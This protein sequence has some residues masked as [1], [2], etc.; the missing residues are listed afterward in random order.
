VPAFGSDSA[1]GSMVL[2]IFC[3]RFFRAE[4]GKTEHQKQ[5]RTDLPKVKK[6]RLRKF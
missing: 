2:F 4:R 5:S 6:R 1:F 3:V